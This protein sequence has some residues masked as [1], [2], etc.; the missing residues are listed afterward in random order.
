MYVCMCVCVFVCMYACMYVCTYVCVCVCSKCL[1]RV[2]RIIR[3]ECR[4]G[5][6]HIRI[7]KHPTIHFIYRLFNNSTYCSS[8]VTTGIEIISKLPWLHMKKGQRFHKFNST[9]KTLRIKNVAVSNMVS[10]TFRPEM[11]CFLCPVRRA[12]VDTNYV[13][14]KPFLLITK[15]ISSFSFSTSKDPDCCQTIAGSQ[16]P[17]SIT[18]Y[19]PVR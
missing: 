13:R 19:F 9:R 3:F 7:L 1:T 11:I 10:S 12:Q 15:Y 6:S 18:V 17:H 14:L 8:R 5:K 2:S 16:S 4:L